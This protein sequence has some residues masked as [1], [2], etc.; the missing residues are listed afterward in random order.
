VLVE[1]GFA[2]Y[3]P[4]EIN[5]LLRSVPLHCG[6]ENLL[7]YPLHRAGSDLAYALGLCG[8]V[9]SFHS[10]F[11]ILGNRLCATLARLYSS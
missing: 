8:A 9:E 2:A 4:V 1:E 11:F 5:V 3:C 10:D 6:V 7:Q